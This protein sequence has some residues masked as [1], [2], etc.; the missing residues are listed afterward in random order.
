MQEL[1]RQFAGGLIVIL[2]IAAVIAAGINFQQQKRF[3][4]P[5]D[6]VTWVDREGKAGTVAGGQEIIRNNVVALHIVKGGPAD[7]AGIIEGDILRR[8]DNLGVSTAAE[9]SEILVGMGVWKKVE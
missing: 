5:E 6:G 2:T 7:R 3:H 4:L 9:V 1:K 8:I